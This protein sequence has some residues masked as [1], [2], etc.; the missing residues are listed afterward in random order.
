M[1]FFSLIPIIKTIKNGLQFIK[2]IYQ[3]MTNECKVC[4]EYMI[5]YNEAG[6]NNTKIK[7][8]KENYI[9]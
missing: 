3:Q 7:I 8:K 2:I 1:I 6:L 4:E 5:N 9:K